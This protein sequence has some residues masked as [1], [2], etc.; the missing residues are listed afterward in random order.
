MIRSGAGP[1]Y[2]VR[3]S[4]IRTAHA[5]PRKIPLA[6]TGTPLEPLPRTSAALG[7]EVWLKR[8]DHTGSEL[9]GQQGP[10]ARVPDGRGRSIRAPT[11]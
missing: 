3:M 2:D 10:Q 5:D 11:P 1:G 8:D 7:V 9:I 4:S 6:R